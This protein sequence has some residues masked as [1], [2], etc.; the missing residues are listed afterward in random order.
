MKL[1]VQTINFEADDKLLQMVNVHIRKLSS[2]ENKIIGADVYLK[3]LPNHEQQ[4]KTVEIKLYVPGNDLYAEHHADTFDEALLQ[5]VKK[6]KGQI[7]KRKDMLQ[8]RP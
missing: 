3:S 6:M 5:T 7:I 2:I 8:S 4:T 1:D